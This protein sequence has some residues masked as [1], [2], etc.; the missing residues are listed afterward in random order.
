MMIPKGGMSPPNP[1]T[2][3][4][5][6]EE[7][8]ILTG[9]GRTDKNNQNTKSHQIKDQQLLEP[10]PPLQL[11]ESVMVEEQMDK[12]VEEPRQPRKRSRQIAG[13]KSPT[14]ASMSHL[15][16]SA[17]R[18]STMGTSAKINQSHLT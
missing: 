15:Q 18:M 2:L 1:Q 4:R 9:S 7:E 11:S 6:D 16:L 8:E 12:I 14:I 17:E 10:I 13:D 3:E 5:I